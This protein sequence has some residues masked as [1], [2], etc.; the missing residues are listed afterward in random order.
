M[1]W[2][3]SA[4]GS[5]DAEGDGVDG[6]GLECRGRRL[7]QLPTTAARL[8]RSCLC[9]PGA[10]SSEFVFMC[11]MRERDVA[12][13]CPLVSHG[14][15]STN[16]RPERTLP[17]GVHGLRT[18]APRPAYS[19]TSTSGCTHSHPSPSVMAKLPFLVANSRLRIL[20]TVAGR[21]AAPDLLV[22][23]GW[24]GRLTPLPRALW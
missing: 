12:L 11:S 19:T 6:R 13:P 3:L 16:S 17:L 5:K 10:R 15:L 14:D 23:P 20:S 22:N 9:Q 18:V 21:R 7:F 1:R 8:L 2:P 4:I 24:E